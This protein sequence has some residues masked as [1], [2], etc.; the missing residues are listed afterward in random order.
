MSLHDAQ[1][2]SEKLSMEDSFK[3]MA[4]DKKAMKEARE[5]SEAILA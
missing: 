2:V 4:Q 3:A 1:R 5:W